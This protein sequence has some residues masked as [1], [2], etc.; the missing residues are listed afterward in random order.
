MVHGLGYVPRSAALHADSRRGEDDGEGSDGS[1]GGF[2]GSH[3]QGNQLERERELM[4]ELSGYL[5]VHRPPPVLLGSGRTKLPDKFCATMHALALEAPSP[6]GLSQLCA[7]VVSTTTDMGIE[8]SISRV[9]AVP[10]NI[11]LPWMMPPEPAVRQSSTSDGLDDEWG[12]PPEF[13]WPLVGFTSSMPIPG[14]LHVISNIA[15]SV[16]SSSKCLDET[17]SKLAAVSKLVRREHTRD[18]LLERCFSDPIGRCFQA[19]LKR[20]K[21]KVHRKRWGQSHS[22]LRIS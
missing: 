6:E 7:E 8:F 1:E 21:G 12:E 9:D 14:L 20:F 2:D 13:Q 10:A 16:A 18:R 5:E 15:T 19:Q 17:V 22:V 4:A 3:N 11:A